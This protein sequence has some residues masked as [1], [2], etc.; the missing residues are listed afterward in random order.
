MCSVWYLI[1]TIK[2]WRTSL[3]CIQ[4]PAW[5][6]GASEL[7]YWILL[8][9]LK[10]PLSM[11]HFQIKLDTQFSIWKKIMHVKSC[12]FIFMFGSSSD[13]CL[14]LRPWQASWTFFSITGHIYCCPA[15]LIWNVIRK[16]VPVFSNEYIFHWF[17]FNI[18]PILFLYFC[19]PN[20]Y[21]HI[22]LKPIVTWRPV[23]LADEDYNYTVL[24]KSW[25]IWIACCEMPMPSSKTMRMTCPRA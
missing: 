6:D 21:I 4:V 12:H 15:V 2:M 24:S 22:Y 10:Q 17:C 14:Y 18:F 8:V 13:C 11:Y 7:F 9:T 20:S 1:I 23:K 5:I 19:S 25:M 3:K 16:V